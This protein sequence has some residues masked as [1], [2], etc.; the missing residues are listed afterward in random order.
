MNQVVAAADRSLVII[1]GG[2]APL[3][4]LQVVVIGR[5]RAETWDGRPFVGRGLISRLVDW[6]IGRE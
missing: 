5:D 4:R 6:L 1:P 3:K 2:V